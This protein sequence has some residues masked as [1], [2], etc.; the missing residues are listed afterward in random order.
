[1]K[2]NNNQLLF[3]SVAAAQVLGVASVAVERR[4]NDVVCQYIGGQ[5]AGATPPSNET[6]ALEKRANPQGV[7]D[8][9][10]QHKKRATK[11]DLT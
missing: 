6:A 4:Q 1:M 5:F 2:L 10:E 9:S 11:A 3:L 7:S 8:P